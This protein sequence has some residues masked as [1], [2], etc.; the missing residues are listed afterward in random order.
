MRRCREECEPY[1]RILIHLYN[2]SLSPGYLQYA[3]GRLEPMLRQIDP[4]F[5]ETINRCE[6][7][8]RKIQ[9]KYRLQS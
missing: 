4:M 7:A 1:N 6:E 2:L 3:D 9:E 8:I 5:A